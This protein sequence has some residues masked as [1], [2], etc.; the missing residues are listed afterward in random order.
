MNAEAKDK[1]DLLRKKFKSGKNLEE[2]A[3][4]LQRYKAF[5]EAKQMQEAD[6]E[7]AYLPT[8]EPKPWRQANPPFRMTRWHKYKIEEDWNQVRWV[9]LR[10]WGYQGDEDMG[11]MVQIVDDGWG[12]RTTMLTDR[13]IRETESFGFAKRQRVYIHKSDYVWVECYDNFPTA[14]GSRKIPYW[15]FQPVKDQWYTILD[16]HGIAAP[17]KGNIPFQT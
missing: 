6:E 9:D 1:D 7:G 16:T 13:P 12:W 17:A 2:I 14:E 10:L 15:E 8:T 3:I 5:Q 11:H 4:G